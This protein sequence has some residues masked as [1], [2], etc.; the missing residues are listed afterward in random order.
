MDGWERKSSGMRSRSIRA[1][2]GILM[3]RNDRILTG[4]STLIWALARRQTRC[5]FAGSIWESAILLQCVPL[6]FRFPDLSFVHWSKFIDGSGFR[7][8][9]T[10]AV[11]GHLLLICKWTKRV[12]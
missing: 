12:W 11:V 3:A 4:A 10:R 7:V 8:I 5:R 1:D 6:G 9:G 2:A